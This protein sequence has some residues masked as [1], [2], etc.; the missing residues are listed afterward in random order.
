M[1]SPS[2]RLKVLLGCYA[3][4][5][6]FGSEPGT[7]W[8]F[9]KLIAKSHDVH[10][11][12]EKDEF[13]KN[14]TKYSE[15]HPEEVSNISFHFIRRR[16]H[17]LLR[18][19]WPP[20]YYWFYNIWQKAAYRYAVK[21]HEKEH[22][23]LV[24]QINLVGFRAPGELW[25]LNIPYI[26]G[27][28]GGL[29]HTA[30]SLLP[31]MGIYGTIFYSM[32]NILNA[33]HKRWSK[34][35]RIV[36]QKAH[37]I[38]VSDPTAC[39]DIRKLWNRDCIAMRE[40][41]TTRTAPFNDIST[42]SMDSPLQVCWAG[43]HEPRKGLNLLLQAVAL[44]KQ[45]VHVHILG[46]GPYTTRW[47]QLAQK[48]QIEKKVTFYGKIPH[49][50]VFNMMAQSHVF[51]ITSISEGGTPNIVME[52][53]QHNLPIVALN[54]CAYSSVIDESCGIKIDIQPSR[55]IPQKFAD[56]LDKIAASEE[57]RQ[58]LAAGAHTRS[59]SYSWESKLQLINEVY[60]KAV[61]EKGAT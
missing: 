5:P 14:I 38:F 59:E 19:I 10:V 34:A 58:Q 33:I 47:K 35:A 31:N 13:E 45:P 28:I 1:T 51:C 57:L 39:N 20:S 37:T 36:S 30:W 22:F 61:R 43:I 60:E 50:E 48:L 16:H 21:L 53:L 2:K 12:V 24:H 55:F 41:G 26:W 29:N 9:V 11:I 40:V 54:H 4:D 46:Q 15:E 6:N 25:K 3:C 44:C 42:R 49:D 18:K 17:N 8:Q 32:R 23:D 27:P 7:G 52:A 56:A